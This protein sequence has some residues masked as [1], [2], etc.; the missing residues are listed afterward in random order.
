MYS[1]K[2]RLLPVNAASLSFRQAALLHRSAHG[3]AATSAASCLPACAF[4]DMSTAY[5]PELATAD[6]KMKVG[7]CP[8]GA[9][10]SQA[11]K[12]RAPMPGGV[13]SKTDRPAGRTG[14]SKEECLLY[15]QN[16]DQG[17]Q[18]DRISECVLSFYTLFHFTLTIL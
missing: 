11:S 8:Q 17:H 5:R 1:W 12:D 6:T 3:K 15:G 13:S 9:R 10:N 7:P 18:Q 2:P 14:F 4:L 16:R